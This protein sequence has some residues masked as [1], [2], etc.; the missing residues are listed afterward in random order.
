MAGRQQ[1]SPI[2]L[3][4]II[5]PHVLAKQTWML[6]LPMQHLPPHSPQIKGTSVKSSTHSSHKGAFQG[7]PQSSERENTPGEKQ[8][9]PIHHSTPHPSNHL[10]RWHPFPCWTTCWP[11]QKATHAGGWQ[12][13]MLLIGMLSFMNSNNVWEDIHAMGTTLHEVSDSFNGLPEMIDRQTYAFNNVTK[14]YQDMVKNIFK[15]LGKR[16]LGD[17][18]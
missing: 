3:L 12:G 4:K 1:H 6:V 8:L 9:Y 5:R 11:C 13:Q 7:V 17:M 16:V 2:S 18:P 15:F 14:C 10:P